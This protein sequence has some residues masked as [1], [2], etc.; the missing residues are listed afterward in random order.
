MKK[1]F[2]LIAIAVLFNSCSVEEEPEFHYEILAVDS[3][4]APETFI[5]NET[6]AIKVFY[7]KPTTCHAFQGFY[8]DTSGNVRTVAVQS[9]N[10]TY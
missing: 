5:F 8:F 9:Y 7:K 2:W 3:Y 4:I 10:F 1:F 6:H